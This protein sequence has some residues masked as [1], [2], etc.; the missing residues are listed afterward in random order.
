MCK[1]HNFIKIR[2]LKHPEFISSKSS[3]KCY[4]IKVSLNISLKVCPLLLM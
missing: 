2:L 1:I 4:L 3:N